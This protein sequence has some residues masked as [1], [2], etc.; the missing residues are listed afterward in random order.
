MY[1]VVMLVIPIESMNDLGRTLITAL[2]LTDESK[3]GLTAASQALVSPVI[4]CTIAAPMPSFT[5]S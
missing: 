4:L 1:H 3:Q 5:G 2:E